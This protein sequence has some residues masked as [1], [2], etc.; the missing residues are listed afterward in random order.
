MRGRVSVI[1]PAYNEPSYRIRPT[2]V[3]ALRAGAEEVIVIDD[4][5]SGPIVGLPSEVHL[6]RQDHRGISVALNHGRSRATGY[7]LSWLSCGDWMSEDKLEE[8]QAFHGRSGADASFHDFYREE[9]KEIR[10]PSYTWATD[11]W[12]D[13]Q[14]C[15]GTM[16]VKA[17][18]WDLAGGFDEGLHWCLDWDFACRVQRVAGWKYLPK[19]LVYCAEYADGH[20]KKALRDDELCRLRAKDRSTVFERWK[21]AGRTL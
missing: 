1:V 20:S 6:Y 21:N 19:C 14:F 8:Q 4:G 15:L 3:S 2:V 13:N 16:L 9:D 12:R 10:R 11:L 17:W 5:S 18:A 7:Y